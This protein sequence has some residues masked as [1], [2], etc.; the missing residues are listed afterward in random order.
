MNGQCD[1]KK[2]LNR[3]SIKGT[4][5]YADYLEIK[6]KIFVCNFEQDTKIKIILKFLP[7]FT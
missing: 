1:Q 2:I 7:N 5:I 3:L 4:I 6:N